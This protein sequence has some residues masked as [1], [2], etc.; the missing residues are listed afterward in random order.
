MTSVPMRKLP[1]P[2]A[3]STSALRRALQ[4]QSWRLPLHASIAAASSPVRSLAHVRPEPMHELWFTSKSPRGAPNTTEPGSF[5][6]ESSPSGPDHGAHK[7]PS[8]RTLALGRTLRTLSPLLPDI[9]TT[10]LPPSI[11]SPSV[12]LHLFPSTHPH[13]PVVKGKVAYRAA[14]FTAPVAWGAVPLMGSAK[15][16]IVSEKIVRTGYDMCTPATDIGEEKFVVRFKTAATA[17]AGSTSAT[18]SATNN[19][20]PALSILLGGKAPLFGNNASS[21]TKPFS[22]LFIFTFDD[23]GR[24][25]SHTIEHADEDNGYDRT[26]KVV[27]LTDWLLGKAKGKRS[28]EGDLLPGLGV[29][30]ARQRRPETLLAQIMRLAREE[31]RSH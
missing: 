23:K 4:P 17:K 19:T 22:G 3:S 29:A 5:V 14:L 25:A 2:T 18:A 30:M 31:R 12:T 8:E 21:T 10:A 15:L 20:N 6:P 1:T 7:P 9:L 11:V 26:S 16:S 13:L 27:T 28:E 24:I